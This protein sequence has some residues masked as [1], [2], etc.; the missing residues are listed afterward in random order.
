MTGKAKDAPD[1][2]VILDSDLPEYIPEMLSATIN[3]LQE[4]KN[5]VV[6]KNAGGGLVVY[7]DGQGSDGMFCLVCSS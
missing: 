5:T 1:G 2:L 6:M 4:N 7:V 3:K